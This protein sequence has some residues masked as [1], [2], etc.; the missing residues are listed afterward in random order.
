MAK[1]KP[2]EIFEKILK[3][4]QREREKY[5]ELASGSNFDGYHEEDIKYTAKAEMCEE[6]IEYVQVVARKYKDGWIPC[7]ERLPE[8]PERTD[9]VEESIRLEKLNEYNVMISGAEKPTTLYYAGDGYW[10]D[11]AS[12][13]YYPVTV[14]QT[15]PEPYNPKGE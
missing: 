12:Q 15:L 8:E 11:E 1:K 13:D 5:S 10:Y 6:L 2:Q 7:C 9:D 14:W 4:L 3:K